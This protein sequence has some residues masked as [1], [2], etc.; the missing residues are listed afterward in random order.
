MGLTPLSILEAVQRVPF[1]VLGWRLEQKRTILSSR[2][3]WMG[4]GFSGPADAL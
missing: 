1:V 2:V 4:H 3:Q